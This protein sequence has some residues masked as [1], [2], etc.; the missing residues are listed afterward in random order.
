MEKNKLLNNINI[1][2]T[3]NTMVISLFNLTFVAFIFLASSGNRF[4]VLL[5]VFL[6]V[7]LIIVEIVV[8]VIMVVKKKC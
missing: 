6:I 4:A 3:L 5:S 1:A 2:I 7:M 8:T